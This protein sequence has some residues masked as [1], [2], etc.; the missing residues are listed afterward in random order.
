M[1][2]LDAVADVAGDSNHRFA[3]PLRHG[4]DPD[5]RLAEHGLRVN[6][7]FAGEHDVRPLRG[8]IQPGLLDHQVDTRAKIGV[9]HG[10]QRHADAARRPGSGMIGDGRAGTVVRTGTVARRR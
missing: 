8:G 6:R 4:G 7:T 2:T 10:E 9:Q 1:Q 5:R 3:V